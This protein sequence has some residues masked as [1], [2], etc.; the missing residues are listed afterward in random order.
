MPIAVTILKKGTDGRSRSIL[1]TLALTGTY[2]T[3]GD[4]LDF[5]PHDRLQ[6]Q[7]DLVRVFSKAGFVYQY[8]HENKKLLSYANTAGGANAPLGEHTNATYV[9]GILAD[10]PRFEATWFA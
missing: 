6:K 5:G 3:L 9:A 8:D 2:P 4:P 7:P 1:G 10:V